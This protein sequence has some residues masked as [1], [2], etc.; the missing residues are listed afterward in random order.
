[1]KKRFPA[2]YLSTLFILFF[3]TIVPAQIEETLQ[4]YT[5]NNGTG[6]IQP[7]VDG[8]GSSMNR[9]WYQTAHIP[10]IGLRLRLSVTVMMAPVLDE[11]RTFTATTEGI[12]T[13]VQT[14]TVPTIVG[15]EQSVDVAGTGGSLYTFPGGLDMN[16]TGFAIP[17]LTVGSFMGTSA[18]IRFFSAELGD[19]E[20]GKLELQGY[21]INHSLSQYIPFFPMSISVGAF[22]QNVDIGDG[23]V[24]FTTTH[25][26]LQASK[27]FGLLQLYGGAGYDKTD[28]T[29][30]YEFTDGSQT[31]NLN[32][33][34][35][36]DNGLEMTIGAGFNLFILRIYADYSFGTRTVYSAGVSLGI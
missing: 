30:D 36:G 6:Y 3:T 22:W 19:T 7:L 25:Y 17:Q 14:A 18:T 11:D 31:Y 20:L 1:M 4:R 32:Y 2:F 28:A 10:T 5:E 13:P 26:G 16:M 9:G 24:E 29:V 33:E 15:G 21:G 34:M 27:G 35:E 23:L 8:F 12:F